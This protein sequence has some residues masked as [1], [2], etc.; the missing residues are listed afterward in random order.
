MRKKLHK[1]M[2]VDRGI[3]FTRLQVH[4][5][6][7]LRDVGRKAWGRPFNFCA[8]SATFLRLIFLI[9]VTFIS[10]NQIRYFETLRIG[11]DVRLN[12]LVLLVRGLSMVILKQVVASTRKICRLEIVIWLPWCLWCNCLWYWYIWR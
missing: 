10:K 7:G 11:I 2:Y 8:T 4:R 3:I 5:P 1:L 12:Y 9:F 6:Q